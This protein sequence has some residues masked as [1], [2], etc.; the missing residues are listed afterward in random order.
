[1]I[2]I[3]LNPTHRAMWGSFTDEQRAEGYRLHAE[4]TKALESSGEYVTSAALADPA[5]GVRID[6]TDGP[7]AETKEYLAGFYVVD[8]DSLERAIELGRQLPETSLG[9]V[10]VRPLA[11]LGE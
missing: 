9:A 7:F 2:L 4:F 11:Q 10:E 3:Q 6:A 8:C 1:M 5:Q